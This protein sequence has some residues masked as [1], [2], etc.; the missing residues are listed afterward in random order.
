MDRRLLVPLVVLALLTSLAVGVGAGGTSPARPAA[1]PTASTTLSGTQYAGVV[2]AQHVEVAAEHR[3]F[4]LEGR[5]ANATT[6]ASTAAVVA[7]EVQ[8]I[9]WRLGAL[10]ARQQTWLNRTDD[11]EDGETRA[12]ATT[13]VAQR[14][15]L[16]RHIRRLQAVAS[17]LPTD[18][19][20]RYSIGPAVFRSLLDR[21][22][23]LTTPEMVDMAERLAGDEVGDELETAEEGG[24]GEPTET[25]GDGETTEIGGDGSDSDGDGSGTGTPDGGGDEPTNTETDGDGGEASGGEDSESDDG[26]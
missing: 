1:T 22:A 13:I 18:V 19:R 17:T 10:E 11:E 16:E 14:V 2:A 7:D 5:L 15:S 23:A 20:E 25:E 9:R 24:E 8:W 12:E 26:T 4:T 6:D 21:I 3:E